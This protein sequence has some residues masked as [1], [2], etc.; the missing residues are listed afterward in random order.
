MNV[1]ELTLHLKGQGFQ[2]TSHKG[3][4]RLAYVGDFDVCDQSIQI[5]LVFPSQYPSDFPKAYI[6]GWDTNYDLQKKIGVV[7]INKDGEL[8]YIDTDEV[9]WDS[10]RYL[11]FTQTVIDRIRKILKQ[12]TTQSIGGDLFIRDF[13]SYWD[14]KN[15][16]SRI[17][18]TEKKRYD[19]QTTEN[20]TWLQSGKKKDQSK[21]FSIQID[22][23][24]IP[25]DYKYWPP[26][27]LFEFIKWLEPINFFYKLWLKCLCDKTKELTIGKTADKSLKIGFVFLFKESNFKT[28]VPPIAISFT[29]NVRLR[30]ALLGRRLKPLKSMSQGIKLRRYSIRQADSDFIYG[31]NMIEQKSILINK[32]I[33]VIGAGAIGGFLCSQLA[34]LGAGSGKNGKLIIID[35]DILKPENIGRHLLG[36]EYITTSKSES[37]HSVLSSNHPDLNI[38]FFNEQFESVIEQIQGDL[39]INAT[40]M[41]TVGVAL[42]MMKKSHHYPILHTWIEGQGACART[43]LNDHKNH[44]CFRC[45]WE[46]TEHGLYESTIPVL[47]PGS[48]V[49]ITPVGCHQSYFAYPV[50]AAIKAATLASDAVIEFFKNSPTPRLRNLIIRKNQCLNILDENE[51]P[52]STTC[53]VC[54][55]QKVKNS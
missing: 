47:K 39:I 23:L 37:V 41:Q 29:L 25:T 36:M 28:N 11:E 49:E 50:M 4:R 8:C 3:S 2:P 44:A 27:T 53:P 13:I 6:K 1:Q 48:K 42:E 20:I 12:K 10:S 26:S 33:V 19:F 34:C 51:P 15:I 14:G 5:V 21:Y 7:N 9:W 55:S 52:K 38:V 22:T 35:N 24:P 40:G 16:Y 30:N 43:L 31:R 17:L 45:L 32:K 54:Q 18:L 46:Q